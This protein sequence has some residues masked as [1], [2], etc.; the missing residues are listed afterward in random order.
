M[1]HPTPASLPE[2]L[3]RCMLPADRRALKLETREELAA[4]YE[5]ASE[6]E[7][8]RTVEAWLRQRGYWPRT[9]EFLEEPAF[10]PQSGWY[11]HLHETKRNPYLL[12]LL[13]L[14]LDGRHIEIELKTAT[15]RIRPEQAAIL[16]AGGSVVLCRSAQ[17]AIDKV[18][19]WEQIKGAK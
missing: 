15:G 6:R 1:K 4:A 9:P 7:I 14:R 8:Q 13:V 12:D 2:S 18:T 5:A 19:E 3:I 16:A 10:S 17:E 11:I